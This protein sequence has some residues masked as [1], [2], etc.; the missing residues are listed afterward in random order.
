[1]AGRP[2]SMEAAGNS[3]E[4]QSIIVHKAELERLYA[5]ESSE[6]SENHIEAKERFTQVL[7]ELRAEIGHLPRHEI[8]LEQAASG[9]SMPNAQDVCYL[10]GY[11][12]PYPSALKYKQAHAI[13]RTA[14]QALSRETQQVLVPH[15][16]IIKGCRSSRMG[17]D[18]IYMNLAKITKGEEARQK[19][20]DAKSDR[21]AMGRGESFYPEIGHAFEDWYYHS[22]GARQQLES[23]LRN[24]QDLQ[25]SPFREQVM[26]IIAS[27]QDA[28]DNARDNGDKN[29]RLAV[30]H[31]VH[32]ME[33][34]LKEA[35]SYIL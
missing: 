6:K 31:L 18:D 3:I 9:A 30:V 34:L 21:A 10:G 26:E 29:M 35:D 13:L 11:Y 1:M 4:E 12:V 27:L 20:E 5:A 17:P 33:L 14:F 2:H 15:I 25:W 16:L 32:D 22:D 24:N 7:D 23:I 19:L 8:I 28:H